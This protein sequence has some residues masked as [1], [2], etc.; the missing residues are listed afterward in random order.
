MTIFLAFVAQYWR[1]FAVAGLLVLAVGSGWRLGSANVRAD[2]AAVEA[3]HAEQ[4]A[5]WHRQRAEA[6]AAVLARQTALQTDVDKAREDLN[7]ARTLIAEQGTRIARLSVDSDGL[8]V[9]LRAY[10]AGAG[11][12]DTVAA[13]Q[14]RA[15]ALANLLAE[16]AGLAAEAGNLARQ[17]AIDHDER[18]AEVRVLLAG[19]PKNAGSV[20]VH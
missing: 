5:D 17:C 13:C 14:Q 10:S 9:K 12:G 7:H 18:A 6:A 2:L 11:G 19:W 4:V 8:R 3:R 15:G 20:K 1:V 16:G